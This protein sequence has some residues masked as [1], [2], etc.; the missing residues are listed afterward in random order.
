MYTVVND[1][2]SVWQLLERGWQAGGGGGRS[3]RGWFRHEAMWNTTTPP[4]TGGDSY[5]T[6]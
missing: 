1:F 6:S 4:K 2:D 5:C 3:L